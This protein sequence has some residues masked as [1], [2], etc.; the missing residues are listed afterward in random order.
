MNDCLLVKWIWKIVNK[1][2]SLWCD[3]LYASYMK[4]KDFFPLTA[5]VVLSSGNDY[6]KL[7]TYSSLV[8]PWK[9]L[10][11]FGLMFGWIKFLQE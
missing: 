8:G 6:I 2:D 4:S 5:W 7:N 3:L 1:E 11:N 9:G 10:Q